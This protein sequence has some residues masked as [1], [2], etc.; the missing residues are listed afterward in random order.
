MWWEGMRMIEGVCW[1][2]IGRYGM[3]HSRLIYIIRHALECMRMHH[4]ISECMSMY[5]MSMHENVWECRR[6]THVQEGK[7]VV[8]AWYT[9]Y[10]M[11]DHEWECMR[12]AGKVW[13]W[14][15]LRYGMCHTR[16]IYI[17]RNAWECMR[18]YENASD[19]LIM[20]EHACGE[21]AWE[22]LRVSQ[23]DPSAGMGCVI[24]GRDALYEMH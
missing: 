12:M 11:H 7:R 5:V 19:Y 3:C 16:R 15:I 1:W 21:K 24:L 17:I 23:D 18:M 8:L 13:E 22:L 2:P 20:H 10:H 14:P 9:F 6:M 4:T